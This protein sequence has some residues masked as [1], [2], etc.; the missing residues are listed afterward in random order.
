MS[1]IFTEVYKLVAS[2]SH[3]NDSNLLKWFCQLLNLILL[4]KERGIGSALGHR[5]CKVESLQSGEEGSE[6]VSQPFPES[7]LTPGRDTTCPIPYA[8]LC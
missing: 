4:E 6:R 7:F 1:L 3:E 5:L 8:H 2:L